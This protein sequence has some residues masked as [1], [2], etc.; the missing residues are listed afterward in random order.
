[1]ALFPLLIPS[2]PI[3]P[4]WSCPSAGPLPARMVEQEYW[5]AREAPVQVWHKDSGAVELKARRCL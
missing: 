1:M 3:V 4:H 5:K 2:F